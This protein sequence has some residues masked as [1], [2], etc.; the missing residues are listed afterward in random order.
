MKLITASFSLFVLIFCASCSQAPCRGDLEKK[1]QTGGSAAMTSTTEPLEKVKIYKPDGSLQCGMGEAVS[2][3]AMQKEL[4]SIQVFSSANKSDGLMRI[5]LCGSPTG[6][7][8]VYEISK[9][10]LAEA[11]NAGFKEWSFE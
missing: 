8:N 5:Q 6:N 1:S 4:G 11:L 2:L 7:C 10:D 9:K 3:Q